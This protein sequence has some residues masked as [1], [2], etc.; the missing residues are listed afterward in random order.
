MRTMGK[1]KKQKTPRPFFLPPPPK[2]KEISRPRR[3]GVHH[4]HNTISASR[5][6]S[7]LD[8]A[9]VPKIMPTS[10]AAFLHPAEMSSFAGL[11]TENTNCEAMDG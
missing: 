10:I 9:S 6:L 5:E 3:G 1:E 8:P 4:P 11:Q 2:K 7:M